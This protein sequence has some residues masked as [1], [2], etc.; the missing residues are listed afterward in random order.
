MRRFL[1]LLLAVAVAQPAFA[2]QSVTVNEVEQI[3]ASLK[4]KSDG[5]TAK[6]LSGLELTERVTTT[7][8]ESWEAE[9]P[10]KHSRSR[11]ALLALADASAFLDLPAADKSSEA[12]PDISTQRQIVTLAIEHVNKT[13]TVL[14][15]FY[16]TRAT[17]H[18]E[19]TMPQQELIQ[20]APTTA[21]KR[22]MSV[23]G[24][25]YRNTAYEP[26]HRTANF[27]VIVYYRDGNEITDSQGRKTPKN[28]KAGLTTEG[29]FGAILF[30]IVGDAVHGSLK[31]GHWEQ[32]A[33]GPLA[34]FSYAVPE[35]QSHYLVEF[36]NKQGME[37]VYPPYHGEIAVDP[38]SGDI[39]RVTEVADF[40][41]PNDKMQ[42]SIVVEYASVTIGARNYICPVR[43]VAL[44]R[45]PVPSED[46]PARIGVPTV[47]TF[48]ND[49][50]FTQY[51]LF[52]AES[53]IL[54]AGSAQ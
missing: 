49:V 40:K 6:R 12:P 43:G 11:E 44:S 1:C 18:F 46:V 41:P 15:N 26:L 25:A 23:S 28:G 54:P 45:F 31:W 52:R 13:A 10:A 39:Y 30:V 34:V 2:A 22:Q 19:D 27:S 24:V 20:E 29:E 7:R 48:L 32:G 47:Q 5:T 38:A 36:P 35:G 53:R 9:I 17:T 51:H 33:S 21:G 16:A 4:G 37:K 14:P 3:L 8:L 42:T 50:N